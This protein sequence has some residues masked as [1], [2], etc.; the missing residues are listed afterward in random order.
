[1]AGVGVQR[2]V[3]HEAQLGEAGFELAHHGGHQALGVEGL[4]AVGR[5][6]RR[7]DHGEQ[8]HSRDAQGKA[9]LGHWQKQV[10]A[11][12]L[13]ARHGGYRLAPPTAGQH[14]HRVDEVVRAEGVFTHQVAA[15]GGAAQAARPRKRVGGQ[16][17]CS[18]GG[19]GGDYGDNGD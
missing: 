8:R 13:N 9:L 14:K 12:A 3:G 1:M 10:E 18:Y 16:W 11:E 19:L 7:V 2:H 5:F 15:E 6:E 17:V 4:L